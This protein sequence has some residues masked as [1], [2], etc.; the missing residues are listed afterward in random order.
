M[1]PIAISASPY[2]AF[3]LNLGKAK[4]DFT[5]D[6]V[7]C[8]L[9]TSSYTPNVD[10][11]DF[12]DDITNEI[13]GTGYSAG[14]VALTTLS[15]TYDST[16]NLVKLNADPTTWTTATFTCRYAVLYNSTP[17]TD[18]TRPLIGYVDFGA[19]Q[20]PSGVDFTVTWSANGIFRDTIV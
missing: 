12:K 6:T 17:G 1:S 4:F 18:A 16:N 11:H 2:G 8:M 3:L 20:S 9:T 5:S 10:T 7:K 14:G 15:W 19:D 13:T